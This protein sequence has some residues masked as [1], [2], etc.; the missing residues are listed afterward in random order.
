[1][2]PLGGSCGMFENTLLKRM[3]LCH[4]KLVIENIHFIKEGCTKFFYKY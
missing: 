2:I 4:Y 3:S 1:M